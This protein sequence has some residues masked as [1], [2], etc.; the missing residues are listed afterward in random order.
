MARPRLVSGSMRDHAAGM[1]ATVEDPSP[2]DL[3]S[4]LAEQRALLNDVA[5]DAEPATLV[6]GPALGGLEDCDGNAPLSVPAL[7]V[8]VAHA[9][10]GASPKVAQA[11]PMDIPKG[12]SPVGF[13]MWKAAVK[14]VMDLP[15]GRLAGEV[16]PPVSSPHDAEVG[17]A[18]Q[19]SDLEGRVRGAVRVGCQPVQALNVESATFAWPNGFGQ[20][21]GFNTPLVPSPFHGHGGAGASGRPISQ[22]ADRWM[23]EMR[24][25]GTNGQ[26]HAPPSEPTALSGMPDF[27]KHWFQA[28]HAYRSPETIALSTGMGGTPPPK[29]RGGVFR[30]RRATLRAT[31]LGSAPYRRIA[32]GVDKYDSSESDDDSHDRAVSLG[33]GW[34]ASSLVATAATRRRGPQDDPR[35]PLFTMAPR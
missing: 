30:R 28:P 13:A 32:N 8:K 1:M 24:H 25:G 19:C 10:P 31:P 17:H 3:L 14:E 16:A 11:I 21:G 29:G 23:A 33:I 6:T 15:Q 27:Q 20:Q 7:G 26:V 2:L 35:R 18:S 9:V 12:V 5:S 4:A 34:S 22:A